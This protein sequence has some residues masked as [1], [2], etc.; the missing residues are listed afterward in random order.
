[1]RRAAD[2]SA[3]PRLPWLERP[4]APYDLTP[5]ARFANTRDLVSSLKFKRLD[6]QRKSWS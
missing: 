2:A 4:F 1:M 3:I 6:Q 5:S